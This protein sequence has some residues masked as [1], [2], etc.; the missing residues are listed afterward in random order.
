MKDVRDGLKIVL[1]EGLYNKSLIAK[2]S[3]LTPSKLSE[4]LYKH[5]KLDANEMFAI[6]NAIHIQPGKLMDAA[7]DSNQ[8]PAA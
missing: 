6:C 5:R 3:G 2:Q 8:Q 4:I 7:P 1:D